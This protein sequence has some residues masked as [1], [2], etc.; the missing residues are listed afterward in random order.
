VSWFALGAV[1]GWCGRALFGTD[2]NKGFD[3]G[4]DSGRAY[5]KNEKYRVATA[6]EGRED[7]L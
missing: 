1:L 3:A 2:Y 7:A 5:E 6:R 4:F